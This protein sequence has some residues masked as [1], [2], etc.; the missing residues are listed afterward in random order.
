LTYCNATAGDQVTTVSTL[1]FNRI[2]DFS[3]QTGM[4]EVEPGIRLGDLFA[5]TVPRGFLLPVMPGHPSI[6]VGG[7]VGCDVHGK[8]QHREGN[9]ESAVDA[10]TVFHPHHGEQ[11]CSRS[12]MPEL[13]ELT[14]GGFG[15]TGVITSVRL[16]LGKLPGDAMKV[17]RTPVRNL[18]EAVEL[19]RQGQ[20]ADAIY[21]WHNFNLR[22]SRFGQGYVYSSQFVSGTA[23]RDLRAETLT[24]ENRASWPMGL[25]TAP[26]MRM[27]MHGYDWMQRLKPDVHEEALPRAIFPII[28]KESYFRLYGRRGFHEYQVIVPFDGWARFVD[29]LRTMVA[30]HD[31]TVGLAS[32]KLFRGVQRWLR[33]NGNGVCLAIDV[34]A[35]E[36]ARRFFAAM[37]QLTLDVAGVVNVAKDSRLSAEFA[38]R[39]FP[40][41][42]RFRAAL[43]ARDPKRRMQSKLRERIDV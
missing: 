32:L 12:A 14:V 15:L 40:E 5:F 1:A 36:R 26:A 41:Y 11:H 19:L 7:C 38:R 23:R 30:E 31:V 22:G 28:G 8:N 25:L 3:P 13:F 35:G 10:L 43:A 39:A 27:A 6:T 29:R 34:P 24:P 9:F 16:Q 42:D 4:I 20:E 21:S 17:R 33:F 2:L 18:V 37:D